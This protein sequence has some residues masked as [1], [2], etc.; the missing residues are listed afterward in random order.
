MTSKPAYER[1][2]RAR[3]R[4]LQALYNWQ[5]NPQDAGQIVAQFLDEQDFSNVDVE[6]FEL[7]VR[8]V[9]RDHAELDQRLAGFLDRPEEQLDITERCILRLAAWELLHQPETPHEVILDEATELAHRFGAEQ[10]Y[11]FVNGVLDR[12]ARH[13]RDRPGRD[14][15]SSRA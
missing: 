4:A 10:G 8:G 14:D 11:S 2:R 15:S 3:R 5:L 13:W 7:L 9:T 1:R 6:F 12:A